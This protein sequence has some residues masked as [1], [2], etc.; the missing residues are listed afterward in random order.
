MSTPPPTQDASVQ[1]TSESDFLTQHAKP[2]TVAATQK[3]SDWLVAEEKFGNLKEGVRECI[4][5][6]LE[7]RLKPLLDRPDI[8]TNNNKQQGLTQLPRSG[9]AVSF[10]D[11]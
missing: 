4:D 3:L 8:N 6:D 5:P 1:E 10:E 11:T 9:I 7:T 2:D